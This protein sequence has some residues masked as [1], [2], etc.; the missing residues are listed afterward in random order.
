MRPQ[1]RR[2]RAA[3]GFTLLELVVMLALAGILVLI[4]YPA[5]MN[6]IRRARVEGAVRSAAMEARAARLEAIKR[7]V[8]TYVEADF[9]N[10]RIAVWRESGITDGFSPADDVLVRELD[11]PAKVD[12]WG[13]ADGTPEG[14][15]ATWNLPAEHY[16]T[17]ESSGAAESA[18]AIRFAD[19]RGNFLEVRVDPPATARVSMR[20]W[21][22]A[23]AAWKAAGEDGKQWDWQ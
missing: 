17:F 14:P 21:D 15:D 23:A 5:L 12:F 7:S 18:G 10:D 13:P 20:K 8:Q 19:E 4:G 11:L 9:T 22:A 2:G 6:T 16:I 3:G 1:S